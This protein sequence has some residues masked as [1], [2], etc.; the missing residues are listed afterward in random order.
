M[1]EVRHIESHL[2]KEYGKRQVGTQKQLLRTPNYL[3]NETKIVIPKR[4]V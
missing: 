3:V 1:Y 4:S 2:N